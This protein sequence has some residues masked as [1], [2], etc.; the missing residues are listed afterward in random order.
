[1]NR[2]LGARLARLEEAAP[3]PADTPMCAHHRDACAMGAEPLSDLYVLIV[4][5]RQRAGLP[6]PPLDEHRPMTPAER[7]QDAAEFAELL[8]ETQARVAAEEV[9]LKAGVPWT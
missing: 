8:A 1:M 4:E 9:A 2:R 6:V 7:A 3:K 5:A